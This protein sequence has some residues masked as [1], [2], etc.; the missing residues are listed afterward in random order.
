MD[1]RKYSAELVG[2]F[3]FF[4][5]G[6]LGLLIAPSAA[7]VL[8]VASAGLGPLLFPLA[9]VLINLRSRTPAT[10]VG[11]SGFVQTVGYLLGAIGPFVVGALHDG[12]GG[13]TIPLVFLLV[14]VVLVVPAAAVLV[15]IPVVVL[16]L[17]FQR[18]IVAGLT[19]GAVKG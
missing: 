17:I 9:L 2:S 14:V 12:S 18:R 8:W 4:V 19:N 7:P 13:W 6:Y 15:T 10:T 16:V 1:F 11:L 5:I 3:I